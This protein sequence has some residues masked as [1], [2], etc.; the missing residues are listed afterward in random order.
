MNHFSEKP[1]YVEAFIRRNGATWLRALLCALTLN[2]VLFAL[3]P[4]LL[5]SVD[6]IPAYER[7][8]SHIHVVR[9]KQPESPVKRKI[10]TP[11]EPPP[12]RPL[13]K[14][15]LQQPL[16]SKL[17]LPFELNP[18]LPAGPDTLTLPALPPAPV[19][20]S[21]F[22]EAFSADDLDAPLTVLARIPPIY[23][24]QA[25]QRGIEGW[26][27]VQFLVDD[28]GRV[29]QVTV[30]ESQP[31]GLFKRQCDSLCLRVRLSP[32]GWGAFP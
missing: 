22:G 17:T 21:G 5:H 9:I 19:D 14:R 29:S 23:P 7:I 3:M 1:L 2:A 18:R 11:P 27:T 25:K 30:K 24:Y 32:A 26:V 13:A 6:Q 15:A 28:N 4:H 31:P 8:V 16:K 12:K 20:I 10:E